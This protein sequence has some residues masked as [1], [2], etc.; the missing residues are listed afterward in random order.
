LIDDARECAAV[1]AK[2]QTDVLGVQR[3]AVPQPGQDDVLD[4]GEPMPLE[5]RLEDI[6]HQRVGTLHEITDAVLRPVRRYLV[7]SLGHLSAP[8]FTA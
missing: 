4:E 2:L 8:A 3:D 5:H 7:M 6:Q 1:V